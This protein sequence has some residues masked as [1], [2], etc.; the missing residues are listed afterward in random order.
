MV[1]RTPVRP[2]LTGRTDDPA[3]RRGL[4]APKVRHRQ[5][6]VPTRRLPP[7][8]RSSLAGARCDAHGPVSRPRPR[9]VFRRRSVPRSPALAAMLTAPSADPLQHLVGDVVVRV[10]VLHVV[11]V[12]ERVD[13]PE[14][15]PR[16]L[17]VEFHGHA[18]HEP[19]LGGVVI[20][21]GVLQCGAHRDEVGRLADHLEGVAEVAH[22]LG[23]GLE[24]R[25]QHA[26][27][28]HLAGLLRARHHDDTLA[29]EEVGDRAR[30][31]HRSPV[32]GHRRGALRGG[33]V[34]VV[35][36]ALDEEGAPAA[37]VALVGDVLPVG[38]AGLQART[39]LDRTV[40]VVVRDGGLLRLLD[41][42]VEGGVA[43]RVTAARAGGH[44]DVLDQLGE[45][46]AALGVDRS[47][48]VLRRRPF[49]VPAHGV[50]LSSPATTPVISARRRR[51]AFVTMSTNSACT[52]RSP[53]SSGW[54]LVATRVPWRTATILPSA[55][56]PT[57]RPS[58]STDGPASSTHGARMNTACTGPPSIPS[59]P[60]SDSKESTCRPN[61]LRRTVTS[62][63]PRVCWSGG[64]STSRSASRIIPAQE[65]YTGSPSAIA[66]RSWSS[67]PNRSA[68]LAMVVD[69]PP[70]T[71]RPSTVASSSG[72]RT[73]T[74][75][76]P[77]AVSAAKCSRTSP[78]RASPPMR[79]TL[80]SRGSRSARPPAASRR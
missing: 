75:R 22:P 73:W 4:S 45:Q 65:P 14:D 67:S 6:T 3:A 18:G 70:G 28:V 24:D 23:A 50:P 10:H 58:T 62:M 77:W 27:L 36:Q 12:L 59:R 61:A 78:C 60:T 19:R 35:G 44:L 63:P 39:P 47:L 57:T 32:A 76:A 34:A 52:R 30:V 54:K 15:L 5:P 37:G 13:E 29:G 17:L 64:A 11:A 48:L 26:V 69:S 51:T 71:T 55:G 38:A 9:V 25:H 21:P 41:G 43:G 79:G 1:S 68:S 72:R 20:D 66:W 74:A 8:L 80:T 40:D 53:V 7:P 56:P 16:G 2:R 31:G 46:L 49:R 33:P 42:V